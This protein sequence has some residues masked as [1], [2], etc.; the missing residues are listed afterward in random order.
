MFK[1]EPKGSLNIRIGAS[2]ESVKK[3]E[4]DERLPLDEFTMIY[5][6]PFYPPPTP[7]LP[8]GC[9]TRAFFNK[10]RVDILTLVK[11]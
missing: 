5:F 4:T 1:I 10:H 8:M 6:V 3:T 11:C 9:Y 2:P 7:Y